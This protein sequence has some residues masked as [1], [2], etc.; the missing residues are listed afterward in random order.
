ME[1]FNVHPKNNRLIDNNGRNITCDK[2]VK[3]SELRL[4]DMSN[5]YLYH[6]MIVTY[7]TLL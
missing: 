5:L 7:F 3:I 4:K 1:R 6:R 2:A